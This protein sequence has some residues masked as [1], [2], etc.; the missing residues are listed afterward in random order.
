M[1]LKQHPEDFIVNEILQL[2]FDDAGEYTY[3]QLTKKNLTTIEAIGKIADIFNIKISYI[4]FAGTKDKAAVTSQHISVY[5]GSSKDLIKE[6]PQANAFL[7]LSFLG[8]GK[9]RLNLGSLEGNSFS[10]IV[11]EA[12]DNPSK[13]DFIVNYFDDQRFGNNKNNHVVGKLLIKAKFDEACKIIGLPVEGRNYVKALQTLHKKT[14]QMYIHAYQS[15]LFNEICK[16]YVEKKYKKKL[17]PIEHNLGTLYNVNEKPEKIKNIEIPLIGFGFDFDTIKDK[18]LKQIIEQI[19]KQE[20]IYPRDFI[21]RS[22]QGFSSEGGT[23]N[24]FAKVSNL[25][26]LQMDEKT[27]KITFSLP[28]ASY[29][30]VVIKSMFSSSS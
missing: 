5:K 25:D 8:K 3:Y 1:I 2:Y 24:L 9:E 12:L 23:R 4:N 20:N 14:L 15:F 6:F 28:K 18:Q 7:H 26:I 17:K 16:T 10:I 30:T 19:L 13:I 29:G 27:Y 11:R 22:L 21:I